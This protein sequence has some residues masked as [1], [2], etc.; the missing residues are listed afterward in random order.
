MADGQTR[1]LFHGRRPR[2]GRQAGKATLEA[3]QT[4][5]R[6]ADCRPLFTLEDPRGLDATRP[7]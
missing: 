5:A 3:S 4:C 6:M 2:L 1:G 7:L